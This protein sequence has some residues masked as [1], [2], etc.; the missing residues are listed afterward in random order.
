MSHE[1]QKGSKSTEEADEFPTDVQGSRLCV[2]VCEIVTP[3]EWLRR[4]PRPGK[5][6]KKM[7]KSCNMAKRNREL[8]CPSRRHPSASLVTPPFTILPRYDSASLGVFFRSGCTCVVPCESPEGESVLDKL[9]IRQLSLNWVSSEGSEEGEGGGQR[10]TGDCRAGPPG[11]QNE[12]E[13]LQ[14]LMF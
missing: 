11:R 14:K 2:R 8:F 9:L 10:N 7:K 3:S 1:G 4:L 5:K 12:Q 6:W 13:P